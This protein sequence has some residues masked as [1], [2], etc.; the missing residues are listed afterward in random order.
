VCSSWNYDI[1]DL[2]RILRVVR[3][4]SLARSVISWPSL[5]SRSPWSSMDTKP[6]QGDGPWTNLVE[7]VL[8][9]TLAF[10][11]LLLPLCGAAAAHH[12]RATPREVRHSMP[13]RVRRMMWQRVWPTMV[14][15]V[16][17]RT[18]LCQVLYPLGWHAATLL[19][20]LRCP[21]PRP[22]TPAC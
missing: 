1:N 15:K 19:V 7:R 22:D 18:T 11:P 14:G 5:L 20:L 8:V 13:N 6:N 10:T 16:G 2:S 17:S 4:V 21:S 3:S 9:W 12:G